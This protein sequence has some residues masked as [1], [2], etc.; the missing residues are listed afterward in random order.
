MRTRHYFA[1]QVYCSGRAVAPNEMELKNFT[2]YM[3][4]KPSTSCEEYH[5][6]VNYIKVKRRHGFRHS[7]MP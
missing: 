5:I 7:P 4:S 3:D 6:N 2:N 1:P